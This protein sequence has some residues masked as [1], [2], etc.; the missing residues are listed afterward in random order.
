MT[1]DNSKLTLL[2]KNKDMSLFN[3]FMQVQI[4]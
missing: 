1:I 2:M 3:T 4:N